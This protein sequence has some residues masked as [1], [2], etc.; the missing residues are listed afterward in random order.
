[1]KLCMKI[2]LC[3]YLILMMSVSALAKDIS[4]TETR[5]DKELLPALKQSSEMDF[6]KTGVQGYKDL[7]NNLVGS[8]DLPKDENVN[9]YDVYV[10]NPDSDK[11]LRLRIY[12]PVNKQDNLAG[13]LW[14]HGGGYLFGVPEQDEMQS[15]RRRIHRLQ[16]QPYCAC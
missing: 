9:V 8:K 11:D 10:E 1:M 3:C 14:I 6:A 16:H 7:F 13:I 2:I 5:T 4:D 12:K 15:R